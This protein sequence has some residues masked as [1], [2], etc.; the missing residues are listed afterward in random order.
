MS[1][2]DKL[3]MFA[4]VLEALGLCLTAI[5]ILNDELARKIEKVVVKYLDINR[6]FA[7]GED[8][9]EVEYAIKNNQSNIAGPFLLTLL[10]LYII[11]RFF[12]FEHNFIY[13]F[14]T[15]LSLF[16]IPR[17]VLRLLRKISGGRVLG[18]V[19]LVIAA[20]GV[21]IETIQV[22]VIPQKVYAVAVVVT[23]LLIAAACVRRP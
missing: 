3:Q 20:S 1:T 5:E 7:L 10:V 9:E 15:T 16:L 21:A 13:A 4:L 18:G 12:D 6:Y 19:G 11:A 8:K 14:L 23:A 17:N 2:M 22:W